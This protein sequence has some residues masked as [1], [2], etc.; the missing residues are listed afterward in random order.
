[1]RERHSLAWTPW[2]EQQSERETYN[3]AWH[4]HHGER[5]KTGI[6]H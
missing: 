5:D 1:M 4:G 2:K 6:E 3:V